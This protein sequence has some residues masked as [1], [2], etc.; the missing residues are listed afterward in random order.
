MHSKKM[1]NLEN[2]LV[3]HSIRKDA[4]RWRI[5]TVIKVIARIFTLALTVLKT[6]TFHTCDLEILGKSHRVQHSQW[7][8]SMA[9]KSHSMNF[10]ASFHQFRDIEVLKCLTLKF[11]SRSRSNTVMPFGGEYKHLQK[12]QHVF[13]ASSHCFR[14]SRFEMFDL[15]NLGQGHEVQHSN[16][17]IRWQMSMSIKI[18]IE[19][20]TLAL[21][22]FKIFTFK[23]V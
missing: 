1:F 18:L 16:G 3:K 20:F 2:G 19:H 10:Y 4:I 21:T 11:R 9:N 17:P 12:S 5:S 23:I 7:F 6:L 8:R 22:V 14:D 13:C 15:A